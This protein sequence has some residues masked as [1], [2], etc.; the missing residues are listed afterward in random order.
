MSLI[1]NSLFHELAWLSRQLRRETP[2]HSLQEQFAHAEAPERGAIKLYCVRRVSWLR[3]HFLFVG[4]DFLFIM[5]YPVD[6]QVTFA[7]EL[8][9]KQ[10]VEPTP[11]EKFQSQA[12]T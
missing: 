6:I 7:A 1:P 4:C 9:A 12:I 3:C 10:F 11:M 5:L 8:F 2:R